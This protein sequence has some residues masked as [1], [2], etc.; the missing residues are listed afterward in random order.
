MPGRICLYRMHWLEGPDDP[1]CL[2]CWDSYTESVEYPNGDFDCKLSQWYADR[3]E[4]FDENVL[5]EKE[6]AYIQRRRP[7]K[8]VVGKVTMK[9]MIED[10]IEVKEFSIV[11]NTKKILA[12]KVE[13][14]KDRR[15][16]Y[17]NTTT[18]EEV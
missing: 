8:K 3:D 4:C 7:R 13:D 2:H 9:F 16:I 17:I 5:T 11:N 15:R 14:D 18:L 12:T 1:L 6:Y 10:E